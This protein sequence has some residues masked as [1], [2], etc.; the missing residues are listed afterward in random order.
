[1][2]LRVVLVSVL[3]TLG[4]VGMAANGGVVAA[5]PPPTT[6]APVGTVPT[7][8]INDFIPTQRALSD[9]IS[10]SPKPGCGSEAQSDWHMWLTFLAL[11][12]GMVFVGWRVVAGVRRGQNK[13]DPTRA[14]T[15]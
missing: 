14:P 13:P 7:S 11:V 6:E 9:C 10:A 1:V 15:A 12:G 8:T 2:P 3:F 4:T 5:A